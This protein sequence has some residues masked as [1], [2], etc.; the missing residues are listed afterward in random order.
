[1]ANKTQE[2][3]QAERTSVQQLYPVDELRMRK[4]ISMGVFCGMCA[5]QGWRPGR[6]VSEATFDAAADQFMKGGGGGAAGR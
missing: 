4:K 1:M 5:Q 6:S 2:L 3:E